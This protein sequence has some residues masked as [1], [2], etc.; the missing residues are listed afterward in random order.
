MGLTGSTQPDWFFLEVLKENP[1]AS[2]HL[3]LDTPILGLQLI[4]HFLSQQSCVY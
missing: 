4:L 1:L 2:L 3:S